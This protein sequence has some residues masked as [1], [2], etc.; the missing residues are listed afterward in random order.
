M[1]RMGQFLGPTEAY[2]VPLSII[3]PADSNVTASRFHA[4][5]LDPKLKLDEETMMDLQDQI[6]E[7]LAV[8]KV[9]RDFPG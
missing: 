6:L 5:L 1:A 2:G 9:T 4:S 3:H 8:L 7:L